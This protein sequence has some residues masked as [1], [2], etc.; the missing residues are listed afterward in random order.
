MDNL[1]NLKSTTRKPNFLKKTRQLVI[2]L[3]L[4]IGLTLPSVGFANENET[5]AEYNIQTY[6][7]EMQ[8]GWNLGN[9]FDAVGTDETAWGNPPVTKEF[10]EQ[11]ASQGFK[12]IRIPITFDQRMASGPDYTID[13]DF[14]ERI[15]NTVNWALEADLYVMIN[16]HH[17]SWIWL[18]PGMKHNHDESLARYKAIWTQLSEQFK[19]YPRELMFESINEPRFDGNEEEDAAFLHE[20]NTEFYNIVR[21]SGGN[22]ATRAIVLPTLDT[23]SEPHK[24]EG[25]SK[26]IE[27]LNDPYIIATVHYYGLWPF[28]VNIAGHTRFDEETKNHIHDTFDRVHDTFVA[29]GIPVIVGEFGLLGFDTHI[30]SIQQGEKLKFFEYALHY[31]QQKKMTHMLWD[32]GQHFGRQ[33]FEWSDPELY[34]IMKESWETRS[35]T[36]ESDFIY[37]KK[38]TDIQDVTLKIDLNGKEL[39][40][41][42]VNNTN[43]I[44][45]QDYRFNGSDLTIKA[46][47]LKQLTASNQIGKNSTITVV[48]NNGFNW[49]IDVITYDSPVLSNTTGTTSEFKIPTQFNGNQLATMEAVYTDGSAAGP[50]NWTTFKE[51]NWTFSP[52]Y[53][54]NEII[55]K[56]NFFNELTDGDVLL[57][58]YFWSGEKVEYTITKTGTNVTGKLVV[59]EPPIDTPNNEEPPPVDDGNNQ[60][61][62]NDEEPPTEKPDDS[63]QNGGKDQDDKDTQQDNQDETARDDE[64]PVLTDSD[65]DKDNN[66][67]T[68]NE[69]KTTAKSSESTSNKL[70]TTATSQ[71]NILLLGV[72]LLIIGGIIITLTR[73]VR[74]Y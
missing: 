34:S 62:A 8:P 59:E 31:M 67:D 72:G 6:V 47:L 29:K 25:L 38:D 61:P 27:A 58:F 37:L 13:Q 4:L 5:P 30:G 15:E 7:E 42:Q 70:P 35:A 32:N 24:L 68:K 23:G 12:S 65:S 21:N 11:I 55:L 48:F 56:E 74:K 64:K 41:L 9:T 10:I 57:T 16:I 51:Y 3:T 43:L 33:S 46:Q 52:D 14:L 20:L 54:N 1:Q 17:D 28:S 19:D 26:T 53:D 50:Q 39:S 45:G 40:S 49:T 2:M 18:E 66:S 63:N 71:Y 44:E 69:T 60:P 22:N 73:K 36:I